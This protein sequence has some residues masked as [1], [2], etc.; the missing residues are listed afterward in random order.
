MASS[1]L[2]GQLLGIAPELAYF[3]TTESLVAARQAVGR[4][5]RTDFPSQVARFIEAAVFITLLLVQKS[6]AAWVRMWLP[7]P[8]IVIQ[9]LTPVTIAW[10][11][12]WDSS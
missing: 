5:P 6:I 1:G 7:L 4:L 2:V 10:R 9:V 12:A 8:P 11:V 3:A